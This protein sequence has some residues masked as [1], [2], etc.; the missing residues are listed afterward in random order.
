MYVTGLATLPSGF[1]PE[2]V[3]EQMLKFKQN[4]DAV[5]PVI[6]VILMLAITVILAATVAVFVFGMSENVG[7]M[8]IVRI[9]SKLDCDDI[10]LTISGGPDLSSLQRLTITMDGSPVNVSCINVSCIN[11]S[12]MSCKDGVIEVDDGGQFKV[13]DTIKINKTAINKTAGRV[14]VVGQWSDG[15][16]Q[17]IVDRTY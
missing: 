16:E 1:T 7:T 17:I 5:S 13:G 15:V 2:E 4:E 11:V 8:K 14:L 6:G 9:G 12:C 10:V 3:N